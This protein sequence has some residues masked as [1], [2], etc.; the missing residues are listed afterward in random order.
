[1]G[2]TLKYSPSTPIFGRHKI[3]SSKIKITVQRIKRLMKLKRLK[4]LRI[5]VCLFNILKIFPLVIYRLPIL[6]FEF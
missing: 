4:K 6:N 2:S 1:M 3:C 5:S